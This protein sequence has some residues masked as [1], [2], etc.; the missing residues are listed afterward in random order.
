MFLL[1]SELAK[2]EEILNKYKRYKN[3]LFKLS[4]PEWQEAQEAK[5]LKAKVPTYRNAQKEQKNSE[6]QET[7]IR[8][9]K[10]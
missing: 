2:I 8:Q 4:P 3:I 10:C 1:H 5:A 9:G 7:A 6:P